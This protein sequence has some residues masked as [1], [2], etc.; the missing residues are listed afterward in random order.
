MRSRYP[1]RKQI[2][3]DYETQFLTNPILNDKIKKIFNIKSTL[4]QSG[5]T[6]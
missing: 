5:L 6:H 2:K 1:Y 3:T 4:I